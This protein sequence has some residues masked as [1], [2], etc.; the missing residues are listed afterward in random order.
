MATKYDNRELVLVVKSDKF[1]NKTIVF[2]TQSL[3]E[4]EYDVYLAQ[5]GDWYRYDG[6]FEPA[7]VPVKSA[8][9]AAA[10]GDTR[11]E[12]ETLGIYIGQPDVSIVIDA[13]VRHFL[14]SPLFGR[15]G[16]AFEYPLTPGKLYQIKAV[17]IPNHDIFFFRYLR[18]TEACFF[19]TFK[20]GIS[21]IKDICD[22]YFADMMDYVELRIEECRTN[23]V[24]VATHP[25][26]ASKVLTYAKTPGLIMG[27]KIKALLCCLRVTK[28]KR[29]YVAVEVTKAPSRFEV[30]VNPDPQVPK[31]IVPKQTDYVEE[32]IQQFSVQDENKPLP[33]QSNPKYDSEFPDLISNTPK[34][35]PAAKPAWDIVTKKKGLKLS[36]SMPKQQEIIKMPEPIVSWDHIGFNDTFCGLVV[37]VDTHQ[38]M[39]YI[40]CPEIPNELS[41]INVKGKLSVAEWV[42]FR[43]TQDTR[44][45]VFS[46]E[47]IK[48][49]PPTEAK[50]KVIPTAMKNS[51]SVKCEL[52]IPNDFDADKNRLITTNFVP[53]VLGHG[54][55]NSQRNKRLS[56]TIVRTKSTGEEEKYKNVYWV[57]NRNS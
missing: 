8:V 48:K 57:I 2:H 28:D 13:D 1:M 49:C 32:L 18:K 23:L 45:K 11:I 21:E 5:V 52:S 53:R 50:Y 30:V 56:G 29:L 27:S 54:I 22:H 37:S 20:N 10:N 33:V 15:I 40:Y 36:T 44:R 26:M 31:H 42:Y 46:G 24:A 7:V 43:I 39:F 51:V 35:T 17:Y 55:K 41:L 25:S 14:F 47:F 12:I 34:P 4:V 6:N 16:I 38:D 3:Q 19:L 9:Y